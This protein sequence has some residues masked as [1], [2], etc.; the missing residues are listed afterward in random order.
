LASQRAARDPGHDQSP[1]GQILR[2]QGRCITACSRLLT[3]RLGLKFET[4]RASSA[5]VR[6]RHLASTLGPGN[7]YAARPCYTFVATRLSQTT[8]ISSLGNLAADETCQTMAV[9]LVIDR[10]RTRQER[11]SSFTGDTWRRAMALRLVGCH[12]MVKSVNRRVLSTAFSA[13]RSF[14][15]SYSLRSLRSC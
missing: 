8:T 5:N 4:P 13:G 11:A 3:S 15:L 10:P 12:L 1:Q 7:S 2:R 14:T 9:K 6:P